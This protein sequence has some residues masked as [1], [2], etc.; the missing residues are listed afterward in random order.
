MYKINTHN[1]SG[2]RNSVN[3]TDWKVL[4]TNYICMY[5]HANYDYNTPTAFKRYSVN[6]HKDAVVEI[7]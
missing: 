5:V 6:I 4:M 7:H 2:V 3:N 1:I